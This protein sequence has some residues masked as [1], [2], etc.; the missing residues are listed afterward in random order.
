M[1]IIKLSLI[2]SFQALPTR[3]KLM[4]IPHWQSQNILKEITFY[5]NDRNKCS[6]SL[7]K[8]RQGFV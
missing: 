6:K 5:S 1:D 8:A 3:T 4:Y 2:H 7:K